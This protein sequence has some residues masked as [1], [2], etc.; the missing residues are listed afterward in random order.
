MVFLFTA[1]W[2][3][4]GV[5]DTP[6][7][8]DSLFLALNLD[9]KVFPTRNSGLVRHS[10]V[11]DTPTSLKVQAGVFVARTSLTAISLIV[12]AN[13]ESLNP[14]PSNG[15]A[16]N[17]SRRRDSSVSSY[18]EDSMSCESEES[19][20]SKVSFTASDDEYCD[21]YPFFDLGLGDKGLRFGHWN[22]TG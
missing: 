21:P 12:L 17:I 11:D 10:R 15:P 13:D 20:M 1:L 5:C 4:A 19:N 7:N 3:S 8:G 14:G 22:V 6:L 16:A 18:D 2:S 9:T